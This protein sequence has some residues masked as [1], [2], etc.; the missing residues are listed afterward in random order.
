MKSKMSLLL[1]AVLS[2]LL[3]S[4]CNSK[5]VDKKDEAKETVETPG[6]T[7]TTIKLGILNDF[8]GAASFMG[9]GGKDAYLAY[10]QYINEN[11]G[12]NGRNIELIEEDNQYTPAGGVNG[13]KKL[14][15]LDEVFAIPYSFGTGPTVAIKDYINKEGVPVLGLGEGT[16]FFNPPS[17]YLFGVGTPYSYQGAIA[18]RYIAENLAN[19][20]PIK[21]GFM[22][23]DD[24]FG[25]DPL[26][27]I[28]TAL[29]SYNNINLAFQAFHK[30]DV[31]DVSDQVMQLK[32]ANVEYLLLSANVERAG[33]IVKELA[34]Q[35]VDLKGIFSLSF[36]AIDNRIFEIAGHDYIDRYYGIQSFYSWDQKDQESVKKVIE[37]LK[38]QGKE[39]VIE[40]RNNF[41]WYSWNNMALFGEALK[42][43]GKDLTREGVMQALESLKDAETLAT[44]PP[45]T[46]GPDKRISGDS[47]FVV[48]TKLNSDGKVEWESISDSI[49]VPDEIL[50]ELGF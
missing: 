27:G 1:M 11:G 50:K 44:L 34:K 28:E 6:V 47:A 12:I 38:Q 14:I 35:N 42:L 39:D 33:I 9:L 18:V 40:K 30:R 16:E 13:S 2:I 45:V 23:Q 3:I 49:K 48:K 19:G 21:V 29:K 15:T 36:G 7:D 31:V 4:G 17:K 20:K 41:F 22:G 25:K 26:Q 43:A 46:Y 8:S 32:E 5:S 10:V 37:I 24:S